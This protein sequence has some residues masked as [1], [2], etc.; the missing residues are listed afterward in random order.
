MDNICSTKIVTSCSTLF[1]NFEKHNQIGD[2][3]QYSSSSVLLSLRLH[4]WNWHHLTRYLVIS[5]VNYSVLIWDIR[6]ASLIARI[7][8]KMITMSQPNAITR[9]IAA[10]AV[11]PWQARLRCSNEQ[12]ISA[13]RLCAHRPA[14]LFFSLEL[15]IIIVC[16]QMFRCKV[17]YGQNE[18]NR[19]HQ[20]Q[21]WPVACRYSRRNLALNTEHQISKYG[22]QPVSVI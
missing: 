22:V 17:L 2:K 18:S 21:K 4:I 10:A 9:C 11:I 7:L 5:I 12:Q 19:E 20:E 6:R 8:W 1:F 13:G 14:Y 3:K 16:V 15:A